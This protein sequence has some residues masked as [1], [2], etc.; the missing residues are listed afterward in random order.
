MPNVFKIL[1]RRSSIGGAPWQLDR[2]ATVIFTAASMVLF[3]TAGGC[4][5]FAFRLHLVGGITESTIPSFLLPLTLLMSAGALTLTL[6]FMNAESLR[7]KTALQSLQQR[8]RHL[9]SIADNLPGILAHIDCDLRYKFANAACAK[10]WGRTPEQLIG[11]SI[12]DVL[13]EG[14]FEKSRPYIQ[15]VLSGEKVTFD[16]QFLTADGTTQF[17]TV[18]L[19]PELDPKGDICGYYTLVIDT[20]ESKNAKDALW[21]SETRLRTIIETEP[22]CVM[23]IGADGVLIEMN[24]AGLALLE[25]N[26]LAE[27]QQHPFIEYIS[28]EYRSAFEK[29][30]CGTMRGEC[31][32]IAFE[33]IGLKGQ[34]RW[35]ETHAAPLRDATGE[36]RDMLGVTRDITANRRAEENLRRSEHFARTALNALSLH[37]AVLDESGKILS[38]NNAW[39]QFARANAAQV[40]SVSE[41]TNYLE[42]CESDPRDLSA[43]R[44]AAGIR[45]V[46]KGTMPEFQFEYACHSP[47][48]E[49]WFIGRAARFP[50]EDLNRIII[51]HAEI[52]ERKLAEEELRRIFNLSLDIIVS[53]GYGGGFKSFNPSFERALGYPAEELKTKSFLDIVHADDF[54]TAAGEVEKVIDGS[55]TSF[56]VRC[57]AKDGSTRLLEWNLA[58]MPGARLMFGM[59]RDISERKKLEEK[60]LQAQKMDA[61]GQLA[62]GIAHDFNNQL[63]VILGYANL[64]AGAMQ[65]HQSETLSPPASSPAPNA[66]R[67]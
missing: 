28:P 45:G 64:L 57:L 24:A 66:P 23:V 40:T 25:A 30:Y 62:G 59:A 14:A 43:I 4:C 21:K 31:C 49:R 58:P 9:A 7:L 6:V 11:L 10:R 26:L 39:R 42:V 2:R 3:G 63:N 34:R 52:T 50:I 20:T 5:Y 65:E 27:V 55:P 60:M 41:G 48:Q 29:L 17:G 61:I 19:V 51:S 18:T 46:I 44:F 16:N 13:D 47:T 1:K 54:E 32:S 38:V 53:A 56:T 15:R 33:V 12:R 67:I 37:I 36:I 8:E 22:E 35:V